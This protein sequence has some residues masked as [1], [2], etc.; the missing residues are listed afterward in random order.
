MVTHIVLFEL[1]R[2][3]PETLAETAAL[4]RAMEGKIPELA[5][6]EVGVD[7]LSTER[8][9][10]LALTTRHESW[11]DFET[12]QAHPVHQEVLVHMKRVVARAVAVDY[13]S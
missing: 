13:K 5:S 11:P 3:S 2:P 12:Y 8:S 7:E 6:I 10:H 1:T 4:L 9:F